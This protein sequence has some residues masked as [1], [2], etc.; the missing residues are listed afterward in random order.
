MIM[1]N[2]LVL[3]N[4]DTIERETHYDNLRDAEDILRTIYDSIVQT[5]VATDFLM[6]EMDHGAKG[7]ELQLS[8]LIKERVLSMKDQVIKLSRAL[9]K[10]LYSFM[11]H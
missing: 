11:E 7:P 10:E 5:T 1:S 3:N 4:W 6:M 9:D 8:C 2:R